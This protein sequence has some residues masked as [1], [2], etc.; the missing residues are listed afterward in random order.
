MNRKKYG[1]IKTRKTFRPSDARELVEKN[2]LGILISQCKVSD[3]TKEI[4][5]EGQITLYEGVEPEKVEE[6]RER[7][8]EKEKQQKERKREKER[9]VKL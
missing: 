6:I 7:V 5:S 9:E 2:T 4:L 1:E 8:K 3:K